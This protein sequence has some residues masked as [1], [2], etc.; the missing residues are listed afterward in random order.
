[1][2]S[3]VAVASREVSP[4]IQRI[5]AFLLGREPM[6]PLRFQKECAPRSG[7]DANLPEGPSHKLSGNYYFTRDARREVERP[8]VLA[9]HSAA[10]KALPAEAGKGAPADGM[11]LAAF[12]KKG[13][14]PGKQFDYGGQ[15]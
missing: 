7:Q 15:A 3:K 12:P 11:A 6:N 8:T 5:R 1:M 13:V 10:M 9:D 2:A 4:F 14:T